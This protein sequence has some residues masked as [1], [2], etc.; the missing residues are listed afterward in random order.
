[1][2]AQPPKVADAQRAGGGEVRP[3]RRL[4]AGVVMQRN[5]NA[6]MTLTTVNVPARGIGD[7]WLALR[8]LIS[9]WPASNRPW[10]VSV[11]R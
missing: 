2:Q 9:D 8:S 5:R 1:M 4:G 11:L 10:L 6:Q 7:C 3:V